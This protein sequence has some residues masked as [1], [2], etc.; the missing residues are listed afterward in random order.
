MAEDIAQALIKPNTSSSDWW[1]RMR[2]KYGKQDGGSE[3]A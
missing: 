2:Y 1:A 3:R